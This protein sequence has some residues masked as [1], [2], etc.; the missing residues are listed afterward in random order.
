MIFVDRL[1]F[2]YNKRQPVL[3]DISFRGEPGTCTAILGNNGAGK[4][5]LIKCLNRILEPQDGTVHVAGKDVSS[6]SR[7][8]IARSMAYVAQKNTAERVT[9]FDAVLLG[10]KPYITIEPS[11]NDHKMVKEVLDRLGLTSYQLRYVDELSGGEVQKVMLARAL[12]QEPDVLL[13]DEPTSSLDLSNQYEVLELVRKIAREEKI[14]VIIVIHDL[15]L[16]LRYCDRFL[17]VKNQKILAYGDR[18]VVTSEILKTVYRMDVA[19]EQVR[20][21]PVII[22]NPLS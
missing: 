18:K 21:V 14:S 6:F 20:G 10:R 19:V 4:S 16:A 15:N 9:V 17:F 12:V 7:N 8:D 11:K 2:G 5:T 3:E 1:D 13:L 22:P